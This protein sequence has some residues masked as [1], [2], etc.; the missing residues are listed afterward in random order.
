MTG[1]CALGSPQPPEECERVKRNKAQVAGAGFL[2]V[3]ETI[4][5]FFQKLTVEL[6]YTQ[7]FILGICQEQ[8]QGLRYLYNH[9]HCSTINSTKKVKIAGMFI[10]GWMG[11]HSV[12]N[13][14]GNI[15][16]P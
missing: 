3:L 1:M 12:V 6:P 4:A 5:G 14:N 10:S 15:I 8:K 11:K 7:Q 16:R 9:V 13:R 2:I